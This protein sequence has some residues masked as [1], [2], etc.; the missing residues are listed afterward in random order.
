MQEDHDLPHRLLLGPGGRNPTRTHRPNAVDLPQPVGISRDDIEDPLAERSDQFLRI[1]RS[2]A[3]DH[4]GGQIALNAVD[5][6]RRRRLQEP[7]TELATVG[8]VVDPLAGRGDPLP[9]GDRGGMANDRY[10]VT[11][12]SRSGPQ[13]AEPVLG[14][15]KRHSLDEP[16]ERFLGGGCGG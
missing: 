13:H 3:A 6:G 14:I 16:G 11:V 5:R 10:E 2:D 4:A 15:V 8:A 1:D 9:G 7:G 12:S